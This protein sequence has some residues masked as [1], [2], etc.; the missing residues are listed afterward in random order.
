[1][2]DLTKLDFGGDNVTIA[3]ARHSGPLDL[4]AL[5]RIL[6][7]LTNA[8][9]VTNFTALTHPPPGQLR[10]SRILAL[11][12]AWTTSCMNSLSTTIPAS[13]CFCPFL[14][15]HDQPDLL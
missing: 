11:S 15:G 13:S 14:G 5:W 10:A 6:N 8:L 2:P 7:L 4:T 12:L 1:M 3:L 9:L